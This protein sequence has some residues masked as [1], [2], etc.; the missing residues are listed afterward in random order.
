MASR[1]KGRS[2]TSTKRRGPTPRRTAEDETQ[3][4]RYTAPRRPYKYLFRPTWHKVVGTALLVGGVVL[5]FACTFNAGNIHHYGGH[6]WYLVGIAV[7]ASSS[8]WFG[9]FDR[10]P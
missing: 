9:L 2:R 10:S 4:E 6:I 5:F 8:W 1:S 3:N 7:A